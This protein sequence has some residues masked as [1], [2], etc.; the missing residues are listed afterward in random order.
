MRGE[1][2]ARLFAEPGNDIERPV[3]QPGLLGDLR[4]GDGG[5]AG[6]LGRLQHAA[7]PIA[8]APP[9]ERPSTCIG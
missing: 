9:T 1:R 5:E 4:K 7:L 8:S 2:R 6:L 3:R